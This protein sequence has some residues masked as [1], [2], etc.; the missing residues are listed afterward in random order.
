MEAS[1]AVNQMLAGNRIFVPTHQRAYAWIT[2]FESNSAAKQVNTFLSDLEDFIHSSTKSKYYFGH[3]L[4]EEKEFTKYTVIDGQQRLS[5]I[6]IFLSALFKK[7]KSIRPLKEDEEI[8]IEDMIARKAVYRFEAAE[9]DKQLFIDYVIDQVKKD[10]HGLETESAKP[11]VYAFDFFCK[12]FEDKEE[13]YL[14]KMLDTVK[15]ASCT[16]HVLK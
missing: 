1:T 12:H 13:T 10:K 6:M 9:N 4:F 15:N 5:N 7:L 14:L 8:A 16:T 2:G 11:I 3:F